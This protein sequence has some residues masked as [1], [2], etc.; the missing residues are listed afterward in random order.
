MIKDKICQKNETD[1]TVLKKNTLN[2]NLITFSLHCIFLD[3]FVS[4]IKSYLNL[5]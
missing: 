4:K 3:N 2:Y 5:F 1:A